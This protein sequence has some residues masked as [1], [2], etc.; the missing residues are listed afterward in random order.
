MRKKKPYYFQLGSGYD[1]AREFFVNGKAGDRNLWGLNKEGWLGAEF[2]QIDYR[3]E[4]GLTDQRFFGTHI[5]STL[6]LYGEK[7]EE[8]NKDFGLNSYGSS[9]T[10]KRDLSGYLT[11]SLGFLYEYREKY[12]LGDVPLTKEER[13]EFDARNILV[14]TPAI[15]YNSTDSYSRP[16][17]GLYCS[18]SVDISK[19]LNND[20]DDFFKYRFET[21]YYYTLLEYLTFA[22]R[23]GLGHIQPFVT[24][25]RIPDDQLFFLGGIADV[26][27]F[28]ENMLRYD[29]NKSPLGGK[30]EILGSVEARIDIGLN[31]ELCTFLDMGNIKNTVDLAQDEGFRSSAGLGLRYITPIGPVGFMYGWKLDKKEGENS[32]KLHFAIGYTF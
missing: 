29:L 12:A 22:L 26:R 15:T 16:K 9:L 3:V 24:G 27:G 28:D 1:T 8:K 32:G 19:G 30:T 25:S 23:G 10:F 2:S 4:A 11:A 7:K 21:R 20:L 14:T 18:A 5:S 31:F 13:E 6:Q 17:K